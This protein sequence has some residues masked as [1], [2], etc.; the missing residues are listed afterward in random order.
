MLFCLPKCPPKCPPNLKK[1]VFSG[2]LL[3]LIFGV[4]YRA[5]QWALKGSL[6]V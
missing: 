5:F 6:S 2:V 1:E 4:L 3:T